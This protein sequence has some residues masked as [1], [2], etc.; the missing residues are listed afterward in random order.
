MK[1]T[2]R[3][4]YPVCNYMKGIYAIIQ[5]VLGLA[6]DI[7]KAIF[8][9]LLQVITRL[10]YVEREFSSS[11]SLSARLD[12]IPRN[13]QHKRHRLF[14]ARKSLI[15][16]SCVVCTWQGDVILKEGA[17]IGIGCILIGPVTIGENTIFAQNCFVGGQ[18]HIFQDISKGVLGQG[19]E[20][21]QVVIGKN[22]WIGFNAVIL[23]GV[24]IGDNSVIG[25]GSTV[26]KDIPPYCVA[27]G[28]PARV[29]KRYNF[30]TKQ[31][32]RV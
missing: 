32:E 8:L 1:V 30:D 25:A 17:D 19:V 16:K 14:L 5:A 12:I 20:T 4:L 2:Q 15:E 28:N 9:F 29:V 31:W 18:T 3:I 24:T 21:K 23:L 11:I 26:I 13:P 10:F 7:V 27:V 6:R 22:V